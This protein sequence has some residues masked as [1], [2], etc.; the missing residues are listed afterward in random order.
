MIKEYIQ[1]IFIVTVFVYVIY[2][3]S[4]RSRKEKQYSAE[5]RFKNLDIASQLKI[6]KLETIHFS[7]KNKEILVEPADAF[8]FARIK[9]Q[10]ITTTY[11]AKDG[12]ST[13]HIKECI[14]ISGCSLS[15]FDLELAK[16]MRIDDINMVDYSFSE[17]DPYVAY[18]KKHF[19]M[20]FELK[21]YQ[22][23]IHTKEENIGITF[24]NTKNP[25][26]YRIRKNNEVVDIAQMNEHPEVFVQNYVLGNY[27][28]YQ[29]SKVITTDV[30]IDSVFLN[31]NK[32]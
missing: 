18:P 3:N 28:L 1:Y 12:V 22:L 8:T 21:G 23:T 25:S 24:Y 5:A 10:P 11:N 31:K 13:Y 9:Y 32:S 26:L 17:I 2:M 15:I 19:F 14:V 7:E 30:K 29:L 16:N 27:F 6:A 20:P 4:A